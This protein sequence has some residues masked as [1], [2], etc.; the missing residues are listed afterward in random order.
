MQD[1][2]GGED[3]AENVLRLAARGTAIALVGALLFTAFDFVAR[4][5]IA[6]NASQAEYGAFSISLALLN[7]FTI[8]ACLGLHEGAPRFIAFSRGRG[9]RREG[10][11]ILASLQ[12]T[13]TASVLCSLFFFLFA[14]PLAEALHSPPAIL[15]MFATAVPF[16]VMVEMLV[17]FFRG[18]DRVEE[19]FYF[20]DFLMSMLKVSLVAAAA[21]LGLFWMVA[22][23]LLAIVLAA[24]AFSAYAVRKLRVLVRERR[25]VWAGE[26]EGRASSVKRELLRFSLPLLVASIAGIAILRAD[27]LLLGYL[28]AAEDAGLY[29]AA[30][31]LAQLLKIFLDS[32]A[33][34]YVPIASQLLSK[35]RVQELRQYYIVLT[36]W[37]FLA[38][39]PPAMFV[40]LFPG[41]VLS[42]IFGSGYA[43]ADVA[44]RILVVGML[45]HVLLGPNGATLIAIGG[46]RLYM[47]YTL[48]G[49]AL[50]LALNVALIPE[51]GIVGAAVASTSAVCAINALVS[52]QILRTHHI[53]SLAAKF[54]KPAATSAVATSV[55]FL[56]F[57]NVGA[58]PLTLS[59]FLFLFYVMCGI[60]MLVVGFDEDDMTILLELAGNV[61]IKP[62]TIEKIFKK[63]M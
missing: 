17:A 45:L 33:F 55:L 39:F 63:F 48:V 4:V 52:A 26:R 41:A 11:I 24:L 25:G 59:L 23:Y 58:T 12:L 54:M 13:L 49:V 7:I 18:F 57:R 62:H 60:C 46:T 1:A 5:L 56:L 29:N 19:R 22:A 38:T 37:V 50:N 36:K 40:L 51:F 14:K 10:S 16:A 43:A 30:H 32:M 47:L 8:A 9:E 2:N 6:R 31:P 44:L 21:A 35:N 61:G 34:I 28:R 27:T 42:L 20:R 3:A 53:H 15:R